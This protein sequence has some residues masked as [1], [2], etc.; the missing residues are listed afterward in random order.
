MVESENEKQTSD[1]DLEL[2]KVID[3]AIAS[4]PSSLAALDVVIEWKK[5]NRGLRGFSVTPNYSRLM[6]PNVKIDP[7]EEAEKMAHDVL[8]L[9][10]S[11]A[12]GRCIRVTDAE[13]DV[14]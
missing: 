9:D 4:S 13:L 7:I 3:D 6:D 1:V 11:Y 2:V 10:R 5:R 12:M 14:L 8:M